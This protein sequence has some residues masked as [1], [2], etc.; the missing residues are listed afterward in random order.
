[1]IIPQM[2]PHM[3]FSI[4]SVFPNSSTSFPGAIDL[5]FRGER[6]MLLHVAF[7]VKGTATDMI[8]LFVETG[9]LRWLT[10]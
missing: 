2:L 1:V 5:L 4:K 9:V 6:V 10:G 8:A 7:E 3:V